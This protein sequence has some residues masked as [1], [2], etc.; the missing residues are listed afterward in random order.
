MAAAD[1]YLCDGC[2]CKTFYDGNL[3]YGDWG[4]MVRNPRNGRPWPDGVDRDGWM[5]V[6]CGGCA[7]KVREQI[8]QIEAALESKPDA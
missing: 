7:A 8:A 3:S 5:F 4:D 6:L 1:Y 2:D